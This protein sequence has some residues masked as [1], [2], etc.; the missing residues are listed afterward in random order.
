MFRNRLGFAVASP[1]LWVLILRVNIHGGYVRTVPQACLLA[2]AAVVVLQGVTTARSAIR[3]CSGHDVVAYGVCEV[4]QPDYRYLYRPDGDAAQD[5]S[6][7]ETS[8]DL[9]EDT[10]RGRLAW[11]VVDDAAMPPRRVF[12][13]AG[14]GTFR[15]S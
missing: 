12:E 14:A 2:V 9:V 4:T 5:G 6:R 3:F 1:F 15:L 8:R 13:V 7:A 10:G 11:P